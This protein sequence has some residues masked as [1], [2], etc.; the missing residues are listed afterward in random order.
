MELHPSASARGGRCCLS[1]FTSIALAAGS[2][3]AAQ[4][5]PADSLVAVTKPPEA[6]QTIF[7]AHTTERHDLIEVENDLRNML[8]HARIYADFAANAI[9]MQGSSDE[10]ALG[11]KMVADL[12]RPHAIYRLTYTITASENGKEPNTQRVSFIVLPGQKTMLRQGTRVPVV[13]GVANSE[14]GAPSS[15]VQYVDVGLNIDATIEGAADDLRLNTKV[16]QSSLAEE[17]SGIGTQ[18]PVIRQT[19]LQG[20]VLLSQNKSLSIGSL[21]IPGSAARRQEV[22]VVAE[23]VR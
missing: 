14:K 8:P 16:E 19:E 22:S 21:E 20:D 4:S 1:V 6:T 17:R 5:K 9:S 23:L 2:L 3:A 15:Q 7:L 13:T 18:D 12:D 10:L 11:Q